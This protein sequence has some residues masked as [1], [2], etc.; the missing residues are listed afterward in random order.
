[1]PKLPIVT[2]K[3]LIRVLLKLGFFHSHGKG[4]H[5]VMA[6]SDGRRV[7]IPMHGREL[8]KGTLMAI[9][10]D[11]QISKDSLIEFLKS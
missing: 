1:M 3:K 10:K 7:V 8:P 9:L 2:P 11:L 6:H 4:S 5:M